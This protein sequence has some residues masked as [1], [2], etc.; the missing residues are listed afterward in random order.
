MRGRGS[1]R[2][3][4]KLK[5][6]KQKIKVWNMEVFG[7]LEGN[8]Y[9]ALQQVEYWDGVESEMSLFVEETELKK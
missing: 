1:F 7:R 5:E 2:L 3:D 8:K 4:S 9:S 6:L